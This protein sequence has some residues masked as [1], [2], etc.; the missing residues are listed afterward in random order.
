MCALARHNA[1]I[2]A[3]EQHGW[4]ELACKAVKTLGGVELALGSLEG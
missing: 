4:F 3:N 1:S 2:T